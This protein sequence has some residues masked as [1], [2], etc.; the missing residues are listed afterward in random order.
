MNLDPAAETF[1][2]PVSIDI[3]DLISL[4]DVMESLDYGPN[5]GLVYALDYLASHLSFL[6]NQLHDYPDD[7]L[8]IGS[9][10]GYTL[11]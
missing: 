7:Y 1:D 11:L 3:R 8:L 2:Y 9:G 10:A 4:S 6:S 5:G